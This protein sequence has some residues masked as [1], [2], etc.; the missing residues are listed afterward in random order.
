ME[1]HPSK[2]AMAPTLPWL[3]LLL[4]LFAA[5]A[6]GPAMN[7]PFIG[8]DYV[9]LDE[10]R[11]ARFLDLWSFKSAHF[12]WYR[13][14]SRELHFWAL[15]RIAGLN[16]I[17]YRVFGALLWVIALC[18]YAAIVRRLAS[19]RVAFLA[20][21]GVASLALWGTPLLWIS[22]SQDLWML[23]FVMASALLFISGRPGWAALPFVLALLSKETAAVLP[24][25]LCGHLILVGHR[26]WTDALRRTALFW[27]LA[28]VWLVVHPTLRTRLLPGSPTPELVNRPPMPIIFV[29]TILST[30]NLDKLPKPQEIGWD[31]VFRVL[32][33]TLVLAAGVAI[34]RRAGSAAA[35]EG[36]AQAKRSDLVR[37]ALLWVA[38]GW[39][40]LFLPSIAW[41]AYYGCLGVLGAWLVMALWLQDHPRLALVAISC[42]AILR[43]AQANTLSWDWG[44]ESYQRRA[45]SILSAIRDDL[46]RQHSALP[47]HSRV[48][49]AEIPNNVGL[50]AGRS[51]AMRIWYQDTTLQAGFYSYYRPRSASDPRGEDLF[52]RFDS[53]VGMVEVKAGP[54]DIPLSL[55]SNAKWEGD[56]EGL[57]MVFLNSGDIRRAAFEFEKL[58]LLPNRPDAA[59]Y[60]AACYEV[61][62]DS[63][64]ARSLAAEAQSRM[65]LSD[66]QLRR[67][68][69]RLKEPFARR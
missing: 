31:D 17:A 25:L 62:G 42:I 55:R 14:W 58:S 20:T 33:S 65:G 43:G 19:L 23:C 28:L 48:Y 52:F 26:R 7:L 10:T 8:D 6:Y 40:P 44:N 22:G 32:A 29:R 59:G 12:E 36:G 9:F 16:E 64:R 50:I 4:A 37:F 2:R 45:G 63:A 30:V 35:P 49:F 11:N 53:A 21:L 60:A 15:Q 56:H 54:E 39:F 67:W 18:L 41:H 47:P 27:A 5:A 68:I 69:A 1:L 66:A 46:L 24:G 34:A 61:A 3:A 51:P 57:S 13:P 38:V